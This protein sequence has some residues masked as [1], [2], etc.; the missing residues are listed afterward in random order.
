[1][2]IILL[3]GDFIRKFDD[4]TVCLCVVVRVSDRQW[5]SHLSSIEFKLGMREEK[6]LVSY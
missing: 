1:M 5:S 4:I 3:T 6:L 2:R